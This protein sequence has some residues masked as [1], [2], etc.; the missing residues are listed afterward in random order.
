MSELNVGQQ[1]LAILPILRRGDVPSNVSRNSRRNPRREARSHKRP[2]NANRYAQAPPQRRD[3]KV[4]PSSTVK[5]IFDITRFLK[6]KHGLDLSAM[7]PG[8]LSFMK[9]HVREFLGTQQPIFK[10]RTSFTTLTTSGANLTQVVAMDVTGLSPWSSF[11]NIFDEYRVRK[12]VLHIVQLYTGYGGTASTLAAMPIIVVVDYDDSSALASL[13]NAIQYDTAKIVHFG[14]ANPKVH[15]SKEAIPEGQPDL[16]WV[17]TASPTV[18][19][20]WKFWSLTTLVP[21]TAAVGYCYIEA[22]VEFR[23]VA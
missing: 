12:A 13:A 19:F 2:R 8:M 3:Q 23:Q 14:S 20:W 4:V 15:N 17:T 10:L 5:S 9:G 21:S 1:K 16:A 18:P 6:S 7:S 11:A 22:E